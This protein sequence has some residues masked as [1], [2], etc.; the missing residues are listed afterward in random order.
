M[1]KC[2]A[3]S[4]CSCDTSSS[5]PLKLPL[6][7]CFTTSGFNLSFGPVEMSLDDAGILESNRIGNSLLATNKEVVRPR[8]MGTIFRRSA[9]RHIRSA[10]IV[11]GG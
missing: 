5:I 9:E 3:C 6:E 4:F 11:A 7:S 1:S 8:L 2:L 10:D